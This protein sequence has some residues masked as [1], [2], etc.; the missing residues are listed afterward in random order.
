MR[1]N[2]MKLFS[3]PTVVCALAFAPAA[4]A[5][6]FKS[7]VLDGP[8]PDIKRLG[9]V[10]LARDG[11]GAVTYVKAQEGGSKALA[12]RLVSGSW[13]SPERLDPGFNGDSSQ[14]VVAA[15]DSG[16]LFAAFI[17]GGSLY[18]TIRVD[19]ATAWSTPVLIASGGA[20][21]PSIDVG[22]NGHAYI[23]FALLNGA[24]YDV[25]AARYENDAWN[26]IPSAL[27]IDVSND[28]GGS[29][30][31]KP[32]VAVGADG[33]AI[34]GWGEAAKVYVRR[35]TGMTP[36]S[37]PQEAS[38]TNIGDNQGFEADS[39]DLD[40]ED[41]SSFVWTVFRQGFIEGGVGR[42]RIVARRMLGSTFDPGITIDA[43][44]THAGDNAEY[45]RIDMNGRGFGLA[46]SNVGSANTIYAALVNDAFSAGSQLNS[47]PNTASPYSIP[48]VGENDAEVGSISWQVD[49]G[50]G[51]PRV[52]Y[53]RHYESGK[54]EDAK[55]I[56]SAPLGNPDASL[57]LD[58]SADRTGNTVIAFLQGGE[59][60]R[61]LVA[62]VYDRVPGAFQG[63]NTSNFQ[64]TS[65][66]HLKWKAAADLWGP[67]TY[68][69][70]IDNQLVGTT[71]NTSVVANNDI[72]SG[73]HTWRV[74]AVDKRGQQRSTRTRTLRVDGTPPTGTIS[75]VRKGKA[76]RV[77]VKASD[78]GPKSS[79]GIKRTTIDFGDGTKVSGSKARHVYR[80]KGTKT[81]TALV[82]D[83]AGNIGTIQREV[84]IG[85]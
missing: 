55:E 63:L 60:D 69:V 68:N 30:R 29:E 72:T 54:L 40:I 73:K 6:F 49:P 26:L 11:S 42:R 50:S 37:S 36:S 14:P 61:R 71:T 13:N 15:A 85:K 45:P 83:N 67:V 41:D 4:Q 7:E 56:S 22:S 79:S 74:V 84:K 70:Y 3:L 38:V 32:K 25:R 57:G 44:G 76:V 33:N 21:N 34:V 65:Q 16:Q 2:L 52:V 59:S 31:T 27:D 5:E 8:T 43:M 18:A 24:G 78:G 75:L 19:S 82:T 35:L 66:P 20:T 62:A 1:H 48:A 12:T 47:M 28:A 9:E 46:S 58:A 23:A 80:S 81:I 51:A 53:G 39:L 10:D 64:K 17:N 77:T